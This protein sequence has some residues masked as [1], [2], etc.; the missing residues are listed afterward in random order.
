MTTDPKD[1]IGGVTGSLVSFTGLTIE[2]ADHIV[3]IVCGV[4]GLLITLV[5]TV[6]IPAVRSAKGADSDGGE[7]ITKAEKIGILRKII[8]FL[9]DAFAKK[10]DETEKEDEGDGE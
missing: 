8:L 9:K 3:S 7:E 10:K 6:I 2:D 4:A 1:I 5:F